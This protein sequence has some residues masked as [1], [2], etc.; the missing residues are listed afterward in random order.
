MSGGHAL[1]SVPVFVEGD[2]MRRSHWSTCLL[3]SAFVLSGLVFD[4]RAAEKI[5]PSGTYTWERTRRDSDEKVTGTLTLKLE[6]DRVTGMVADG[7]G[8]PVKIENG[9]LEGDTISF[10]STRTRGDRQFTVKYKGKL[11]AA[12][13]QFTSEFERAGET[14]TREWEAKRVVALSDVLGLWKFKL[15][16]PDGEPLETSLRIT[17]DGDQLKGLYTGPRGESQSRK[18]ALAGDA[19]SFEIAGAT[20]DG[21]EYHVTYN[22]KVTGNAYTGK[23]QYKFG[24][25][26]GTLDFVGHREVKQALEVEQILG[27]W[28]LA[29]VREDGETRESTIVISRD[30]EKLK[31][32]YSGR[33]RE[34]EA[35][36]VELKGDTLTIDLSRESDDGNLISVYEGKISGGTIKGTMKFKFG[37]R[38]GSREFSGT[39]AKRKVSL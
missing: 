19:L 5:D 34:R 18:I 30:G 13:I 32:V 37:D 7:R 25:R 21:G 24:D 9:R 39:L 26:E 35:T 4:A 17:K 3:V 27:T 14:R 11:T 8:E 12:G 16:R 6:G 36:K 20:D 2:A 28:T 15:Q 1:F 38:E 22:G 23:A 29:V 33:N 31:A 10:E